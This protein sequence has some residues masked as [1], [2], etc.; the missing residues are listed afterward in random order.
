MILKLLD[1]LYWFLGTIKCKLWLLFH[2]G[3]WGKNL[4]LSGIPKIDGISG[5]SFGKNVAINDGVYI[6]CVGP[7][8]Y[9]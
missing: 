9:N 8:G 4:G 1:K 5:L 2:P 7:G 3:L 6:Q